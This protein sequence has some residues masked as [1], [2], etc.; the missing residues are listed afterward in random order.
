MSCAVAGAGTHRTGA[1]GEEPAYELP[2]RTPGN[3]HLAGALNLPHDQVDALA[4]TVLLDKSQE[5]V[6]YCSNL[7]CQNS[8]IA[9]RRLDHLGYTKVR[10]YEEGKQDWVDAGP[11]RRQQQG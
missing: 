10:E 9:S 4:S 11:T 6:V 7:A 5:I 2:S 8:T 3:T 1:R